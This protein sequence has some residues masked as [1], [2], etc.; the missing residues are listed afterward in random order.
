MLDMSPSLTSV[1]SSRMQSSTELGPTEGLWVCMFG[2]SQ[3]YTKDGDTAPRDTPAL[4]E[5]HLSAGLDPAPWVGLH[6]AMGVGRGL[7]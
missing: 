4:M 7:F 5:L 1:A 3:V 2:T 6:D